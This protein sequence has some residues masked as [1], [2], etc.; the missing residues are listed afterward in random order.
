MT[1]DTYYRVQRGSGTYGNVTVYWRAF[2]MNGNGLI[3]ALPQTDIDVVADSIV[4]L[5]METTGY[6]TLSVLSDGLPELE[7]MY[8]I[9]LYNTT[10][11]IPGA[12]IASS[13]DSATLTIPPNE[14]PYGVF[15]WRRED[16]DTWLAE[17]IPDSDPSNG[18]G[19]FNITRT[20]GTFGTIQVSSSLRFI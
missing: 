10:G 7:E 9:E 4:F 15:D 6:I 20:G 18:T 3:P 17:D 5:E 8:V 16:L 1:I 2:L 12:R 13:N 11:G 19:V 14:S